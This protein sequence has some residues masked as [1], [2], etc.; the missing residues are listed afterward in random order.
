MTLGNW[1]GLGRIRTGALWISLDIFF[2][3]TYEVWGWDS[4]WYC[5]YGDMYLEWCEVMWCH[6]YCFAKP[7]LDPYWPCH[8][9]CNPMLAILLEISKHP[10]LHLTKNNID[11]VFFISTIVIVVFNIVSHSF[12]RY[13]FWYCLGQK[14]KTFPFRARGRKTQKEEHALCDPWC[15]RPSPRWF[16]SVWMHHDWSRGN[17]GSSYYQR[18]VVKLMNDI[19]Q[20]RNEIR[21]RFS[22]HN[23]KL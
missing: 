5:E 11:L 15:R 10:F 18:K 23:A 14:S 20:Y 6:T 1:N 12:I 3:I 4:S 2:S 9:A 7:H 21:R 8:S 22:F 19:Q 17:L 13:C 16:S